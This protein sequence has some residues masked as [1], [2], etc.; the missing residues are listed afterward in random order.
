[1]HVF[2]VKNFEI[3]RNVLLLLVLNVQPVSYLK[4]VRVSHATIILMDVNNVQEQ[5]ELYHVKFKV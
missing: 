5:M 3:A 1:M 2:L 4:G